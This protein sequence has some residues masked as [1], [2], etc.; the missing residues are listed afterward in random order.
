MNE[1]TGFHAAMVPGWFG[2]LETEPAAVQTLLAATEATVE[3]AQA[4]G[5]HND[6]HEP[7]GIRLARDMER[8]VDAPESGD[9]AL[10]DGYQPPGDKGHANDHR[11]G[12]TP[13]LVVFEGFHAD[14]SSSVKK[15]MSQLVPA[16]DADAGVLIN[17]QRVPGQLGGEQGSEA[18][19]ARLNRKL[20]V[21]DAGIHRYGT[22]QPAKIWRIGRPVRRLPAAGQV[23]ET[24]LA[25]GG[26]NGKGERFSRA[27]NGKFN[28]S[29]N[30]K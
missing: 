24:C 26:P 18:W 8:M 17:R 16:R 22:A 14:H 5:N 11:Q 6:H 9:A 28:M 15:P 3:A 30:K 13:G 4:Q 10:G 27:L 2:F 19:R 21:D 20:E 1:E 29:A 23:N 7:K 25:E 12:A